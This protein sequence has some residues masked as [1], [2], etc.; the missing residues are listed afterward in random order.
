MGLLKPWEILNSARTELLNIQL[1]FENLQQLLENSTDDHA[2][3]MCQEDAYN[4]IMLELSL[5]P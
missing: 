3:G 4:K 5:S 2:T 1:M